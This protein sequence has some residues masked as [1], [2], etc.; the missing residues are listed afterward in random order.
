MP[1]TAPIPDG[2]PQA[3]TGASWEHFPHVADVGIRGFGPTLEAAFEQAAIAMTAVVTDPGAINPEETIEIACQAPNV[4]LLLA[5]WLNAIVYE[6]ATRKML[7]GRFSASI[8]G[9]SLIGSVS[10][11]PLDI[12]RHAPAAEVKGATLSEL[13]V[14][15]DPAGRWHAQCIVD[16]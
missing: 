14:A 12:E 5:D 9:D 7:F 11:E 6:M 15:R 8:R 16:V 1:E 13:E 2:C 10:G 4:E 3:G